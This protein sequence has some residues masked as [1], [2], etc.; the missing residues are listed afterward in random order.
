MNEQLTIY[1]FM[2]EAP[3]Y[4]RADWFR[5]QGFKNIYDEHPPKPGMYEWRDIEIP[6]KYKILEYTENGGIYLGKLVM[7]SF[8]PVWWRPISDDQ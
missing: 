2:K 1:S 5:A 3:R 6:N 7:G 4:N 8:R